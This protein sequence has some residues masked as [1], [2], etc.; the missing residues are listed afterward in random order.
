MILVTGGTGQLGN[1]VVRTLRQARAEV[2]CLVR[3]GSQYFWLNDTGCHYF[4][5]DLRNAVT[6]RRALQ[7]CDLVIHAA[8]V[9]VERTDNHHANVTLQGT[10]DLVDA[11]VKR[12]V[13][14]FVLVSCVHAGE[15]HAAPLFDCLGQAEEYLKGSGL[16]YTILRP[17]L[18]LGEL[19]QVARQA[20]KA[21]S[22]TVWAS[23]DAQV[24]PVWRRDVALFAIAALDHP[25]FRN[26]TVEVGGPESGTV[27]SFIE[28][29]CQR[30]GADPATITYVPDFATTLAT[31][32]IGLVVKRWRNHFRHLHVLMSQD[33]AID[34]APL[35]AQVN[36]PLTPTDEALDALKDD[37]PPGEDPD[38]RNTKVVHRQFQATIY[39]PGEVP[40]SSLPE[41]PVKLYED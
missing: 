12:K 24:S 40:W 30:H 27:R 14:H 2:R 7:G 34:M 3:M 33:S 39:E 26:A 1:H 19:N 20:A 16:S 22:A 25:A 31:A 15:E 9:R 37:V 36:L 18:F 10:K 32:G 4:F 11:A 6:L 21:G 17:H 29:A 41:G 13:R 5:G 28:R 38:A 23:G 35:L 8:G